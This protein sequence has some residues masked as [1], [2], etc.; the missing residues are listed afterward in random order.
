MWFSLFFLFMHLLYYISIIL[1]ASQ[2]NAQT[3]TSSELNGVKKDSIVSITISAVGDL[4]CHSTQY[5][6][7][8][9][10]G[11]S[12]DF[13]P[14]FREIKNYLE[15][16][17]FVL[18]NLETV[19]GGKNKKYSG[20]PLFNTPDSF[21]EGLKFAGFDLLFTA[22]NHALDRNKSG[23]ERTAQKITEL[24][25]LYNG[26][27]LSEQDR[28]SIRIIEVKGIQIALVSYSYSSNGIELPMNEEYLINRIDTIQIKKDLLRAKGDKPDIIIVYFHFGKEYSRAPSDF[29]RAITE[30]TF[31]YG[32][33]IILGSHPHVVQPLEV[34]VNPSANIDTGFVAFSLG[35][36]VSN[37]RWRYSDGGVILNFTISKNFEKDSVFLNEISFLPIWVFKGVTEFGREYIVLPSELY[38]DEER[39]TYLRENDI[40]KMKE[41][42]FDTYE[43]ITKYSARPK[44]ISVKVFLRN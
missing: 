20:Y 9:I 33:D 26:T 11:D 12:F 5:N 42:Y 44:V 13:K 22:N 39:H 36:F 43:S 18:G 27:F 10:E 34:F 7:A 16:S 17:D 28:D 29:Q 32:A 25:M 1:F 31:E 19:I 40:I 4:M 14:V 38:L 30:K 8:R 35:N 21:L 3:K 6:Y 23:L 37:Q 15:D 41:N 2:L 24:G